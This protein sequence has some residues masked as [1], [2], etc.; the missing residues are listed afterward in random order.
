MAAVFWVWNEV[1]E[2]GE[3]RTKTE[4]DDGTSLLRGRGPARTV[5]HVLGCKRCRRGGPGAITYP[6]ADTGQRPP[7]LRESLASKHMTGAAQ[8]TSHPTEGC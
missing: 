7:L 3:E 2:E 4:A 1:W 5:A 6:G 8:Q